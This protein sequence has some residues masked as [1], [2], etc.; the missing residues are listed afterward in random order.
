MGDFEKLVIIQESKIRSVQF[1]ASESFEDLEREHP[2]R[3]FPAGDG[4]APG[5]SP[6][7]GG[8]LSDGAQ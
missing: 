6:E 3:P 2:G 8:S 1:V 5:V 7:E 4:Q